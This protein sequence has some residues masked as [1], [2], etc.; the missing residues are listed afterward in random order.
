M[1]RRILRWLRLVKPETPL[2]PE[3]EEAVAAIFRLNAFRAEHGYN[4]TNRLFH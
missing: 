4:F 3:L 2:A 1:I